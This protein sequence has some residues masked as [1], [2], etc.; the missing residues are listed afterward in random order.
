MLKTASHEPSGDH[1]PRTEENIEKA[2]QQLEALA[3]QLEAQNQYWSQYWER[4]RNEDMNMV[5]DPPNLLDEMVGIHCTPWGVNT[6]SDQDWDFSV[7]RA[8]AAVGNYLRKAMGQVPVKL[9]T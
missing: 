6:L 5:Y 7:A 9:N 8:W 4:L 1:T 2:Y 3:A